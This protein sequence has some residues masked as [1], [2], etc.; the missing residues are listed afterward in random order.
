M[1]E[2]FRTLAEPILPNLRRLI[3]CFRQADISVI[4]T[5]HAHK[6]SDEDG[7]ML[8]KWWGDLIIDGSPQAEII[9]EIKPFVTEKVIHKKRYSA[10]F[11]L[12]CIAICIRIVFN[13]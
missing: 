8:A 2:Y 6:N 10:F 1:Q 7:G 11:R 5:R 13:S 3:Q 9:P 12:I 4:F